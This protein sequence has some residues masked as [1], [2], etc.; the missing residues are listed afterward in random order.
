MIWIG[1][2]TKGGK[3]VIYDVFAAGIDAGVVNQRFRHI[4]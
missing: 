4:N 1:Y 3:C 2:F